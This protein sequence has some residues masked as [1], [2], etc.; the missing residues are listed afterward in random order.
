MSKKLSLILLVI[1]SLVGA[2]IAFYATN[3]VMYDVGLNTYGFQE[4]SIISSLPLF[5]IG[6]SFALVAMFILKLQKFASSKRKLVKV[7][8]TVLAAY[9]F[10]GLVCSILTGTMIYGSFVAPYPFMAYGLICTI[11]NVLILAAALVA[12]FYLVRKF[13]EDTEE[14]KIGVKTVFKALGLGFVSYFALDRLGAIM[15]A[16]E[17]AQARTLYMT[18]VF[19]VYMLVPA[20]TLAYLALNYFGKSAKECKATRIYLMALIGVH[21][22]FAIL[23]LVLGA[24]NPLFVSAVSNAMGLERLASMPV[25]ILLMVVGYSAYFI[26]Q[27]VRA[28]KNRPNK[29]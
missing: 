15:W 10:V 27:I 7:Y 21:F 18:F 25:V 11:A 2:F 17:Y 14:A 6:L 12:R 20:G 23:T 1:T 26:V 3:L 29:Q 24:T 9:A 4:P 8:S 16:I 22:V 13:P 19:F 5:M 28:I